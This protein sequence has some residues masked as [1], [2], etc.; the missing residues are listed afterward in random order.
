MKCISLNGI[1]KVCVRLFEFT[2]LL[3]YFFWCKFLRAVTLI[4]QAPESRAAG[5]C[6]FYPKLYFHDDTSPLTSCSRGRDPILSKHKPAQS[7][8]SARWQKHPKASAPMTVCDIR[9]DSFSITTTTMALLSLSAQNTHQNPQRKVRLKKETKKSLIST[10]RTT[11]YSL[12]TMSGLAEKWP[13]VTKT[14][15]KSNN[16]PQVQV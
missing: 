5:L 16:I 7:E 1:N 12:I 13:G 11:L 2:K 8:C 3:F 15:T 4:S 10:G 9:S 14:P 6:P